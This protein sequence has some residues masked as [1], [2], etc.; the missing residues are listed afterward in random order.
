MMYHKD[1]D[2]PHRQWFTTKTMMDQIDNDV[3]HRQWCTM[4]YHTDNAVTDR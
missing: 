4:I 3:P 2:G 1:N